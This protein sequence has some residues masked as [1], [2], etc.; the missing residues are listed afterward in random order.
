MHD[1]QI[2]LLVSAILLTDARTFMH[3]PGL[4]DQAA[5]PCNVK[6]MSC[7]VIASY[8]AYTEAGCT[9]DSTGNQLDCSLRELT[10][11]P[12]IPALVTTINLK[13]NSVHDQTGGAVLSCGDQR[14][15]CGSAG[16]LR[17]STLFNIAKS[18]SLKYLQLNRNNIRRI[19]PGAFGGLSRLTVL[20]LSGN[21]LTEIGQMVFAGLSSLQALLISSN[22]ITAI[23]NLAFYPFTDTL[24]V[25][26]LHYTVLLD[27]A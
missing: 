20:D 25:C 18:Q 10:L 14:S 5:A 2:H 21:E 4:T 12:S 16:V 17:A 11:A 19:D 26:F 7:V 8:I 9:L 24:F 27:H 1:A 6:L 3:C 13:D 15:T 22:P 23:R